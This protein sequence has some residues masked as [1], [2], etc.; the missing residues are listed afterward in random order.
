MIIKGE[1]D[2]VFVGRAALSA[3][4]FILTLPLAPVLIYIFNKGLHETLS[5]TRVVNVRLG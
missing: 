3:L 5:G 1:G 4:F 2:P